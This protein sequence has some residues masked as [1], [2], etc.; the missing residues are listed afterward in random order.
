MALQPLTSLMDSTPLPEPSLQS[1]QQKYSVKFYNYNKSSCVIDEILT[2]LCNDPN[3]SGS[4]FV[5]WASTSHLVSFGPSSSG[6][7]QLGMTV[8]SVPFQHLD[9]KLLK[10]GLCDYVDP[11]LLCYETISPK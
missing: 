11:R 4:K 10:T 7:T 3:F 2:F 8:D 1:K 9:L 5:L 6:S